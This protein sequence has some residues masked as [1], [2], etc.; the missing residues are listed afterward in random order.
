[1]VIWADNPSLKFPISTSPVANSDIANL[2]E[3]S[4]S[5]ERI[6]AFAP[7]TADLADPGDAERIGATRVTAGFFETLGVA[8]LVGRTFT[9]EED[10]SGEPTV[11]IIGHS[12]WQRRFSGDASLLGKFVSVNGER[13][14]VV[15]IM[16][17]NFDFP[18]GAE[19]PSF[20]PFPGRTELWL[21]LGFSVQNWQSR[22]ERG[23]VALGRLKKGL[24]QT[25]AQAAMNAYS[26]LQ[27]TEHP[28]THQGWLLKVTPLDAQLAGKQRS[29][30][31][32][33]FGAV[34]LLLLIA[35][36]NVS[37]LLLA[38]A[39]VR[40]KELAVRAALG[41]ANLRLICQLLSE[42]LLL[43]VLGGALGILIGF[44]C[45]RL[46]YWL[47]PFGY[48][49]LNEASIDL[50][51]LAFTMIAAVGTTV[52]FGLVPVLQSLK[53]NLRD[54]LQIDGRGPG[55]DPQKA[56]GLLVGA[57][58]A[59]A[60]IL[61]MGAGLMIRSFLRVQAVNPGFRSEAVLAFDLQLPAAKYDDDVK[62]TTFFS[63]LLDRLQSAPGVRAAGATSYLPLSGGDNM[64]G[65]T[66]EGAAPI[67]PGEEPITERRWVTPGYFSA[68][69]I[70]LRAGRSFNTT[71]IRDQPLAAIINEKMAREY[72]NSA[73]PIGKRIRV[74]PSDS[75][76]W[77]TV[78]GVVSDVRSA[79]L[80]MKVRP[81]VY[82]PYAQVP[83]DSMTL[84]VKTEGDP[85]AFEPAV[86]S[87]VNALDP[88]LPIAK[89]RTMKQVVSEATRG[90]RFN[91][92]LLVS[93]AG[94]ALFLTVIGVYGVVSYLVIRQQ[95][96]IAIRL[97]VGAGRDDVMRLVLR[98]GMK[99][100]CI[101]GLVG[102][103]G[104]FV[105][106]R[107]IA[108]QLYGVSAYDPATL[109]SIITL[110]GSISLLACSLP[111][112]RAARVDPMVALRYE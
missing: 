56:R 82:L 54:A 69:G 23:L 72:F 89:V 91:M 52:I 41:A 99:P 59:L 108:S 45:L 1:M 18:R 48:S 65:F 107:L 34:G 104:S 96:E 53:I 21:P 38:R 87:A 2:R 100:V 46:F 76:P 98:K 43:S 106:G 66:V 86:R 105:A 5:F 67:R 75:G 32:I 47:N 40:K 64:G 17:P 97:A 81:Q 19:W 93:F 3:Q 77:R 63:Q 9:T 28:D 49:R 92:A 42:S 33:L 35:C 58:V 80:E 111:A 14:T 30:L 68:M 31:L 57:Q 55:A 44:A 85:V 16:P 101:G 51:V 24:T 27:A 110:L 7:G 84:V 6:T 37:N 71:D 36:A 11:V 112:R 13:V 94:T 61:L 50:P 88:S 10:R 73:N 74:L 12:L 39:A 95:R 60:I 15:G 83:W 70:A 25:Q 103:G 26:S 62:Q 29:A 4:G 90:R 109:V 20:Y 22:R 78:V 8:P 79:S 102:I